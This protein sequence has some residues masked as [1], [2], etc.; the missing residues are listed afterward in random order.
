MQMCGFCRKPFLKGCPP[1]ALRLPIINFFPETSYKRHL[2][3]CRRTHNRPRT[4]ASACRA[5]NLAKVKC[6]LQSRC[7]RCLSKNLHCVYD[8]ATAA[9][10]A[11]NRDQVVD[12]GS[13]QNGTQASTLVSSTD[14]NIS[15]TPSDLYA[16]GNTQIGMDWDVLDFVNDDIL[17]QSPKDT[18]LDPTSEDMTIEPFLRGIRDLDASSCNG[19]LELTELSWLERDLSQ[20]EYTPTAIRRAH[21]PNPDFL[22]PIS[23]SDPVKTCTASVAM[24][25]L[26]AFPQ[27]ML[28]RETFPPFIHGHWYCNMSAMGPSL[29]EPLVN[30]MGVAQ[31]F[32]SHNPETKPFLWRMIQSE[33]NST[34]KKV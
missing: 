4:R 21:L 29:P 11:P 34:A 32:V 10:A 27:M 25:M 15:G 6:N 19:D 7:S 18:L 30:C 2:L 14:G 31:V 16:F 22:S 8:T 1:V 3:Y 33:Q 5:C 12:D 26:R 23:C 17:S 20:G 13:P 28:R 24:Q 9:I